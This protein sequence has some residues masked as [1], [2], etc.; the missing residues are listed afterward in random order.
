MSAALF[1]GFCLP[2]ATALGSV[3]FGRAGVEQGWFPQ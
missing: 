1:C 3:S 2:G